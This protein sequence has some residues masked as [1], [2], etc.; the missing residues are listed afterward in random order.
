MGKVVVAVIILLLVMVTTKGLEIKYLRRIPFNDVE[1]QSWVNEKTGQALWE[2]I[3]PNLIE[4]SSSREDENRQDRKSFDL[5]RPSEVGTRE[6]DLTK[7][8]SSKIKSILRKPKCSNLRILFDLSSSNDCDKSIRKCNSRKYRRQIEKWSVPQPFYVDEPK[9]IEME[10]DYEENIPYDIHNEKNTF[11]VTRGKRPFMPKSKE[12][13]SVLL[14]NL[15]YYKEKEN[16]DKKFL[17]KAN[18]FTEDKNNRIKKND[19]KRKE[20]RRKALK[21]GTRQLEDL[22]RNLEKPEEPF[23][24]T[25]GKKLYVR[26]HEMSLNTNIKKETLENG[27]IGKIQKRSI[28]DVPTYIKMINTNASSLLKETNNV[29]LSKKQQL[30]LRTRR[31]S[32]EDIDCSIDHSKKKIRLTEDDE[33]AVLDS[34]YVKRRDKHSDIYDILEVPFFISR[35]KKTFE[36]KNQ[37]ESINTPINNGE[38]LDSI[39]AAKQIF[40]RLFN[41]GVCNIDLC[42]DLIK[43]IRENDTNMIERNRKSSLEEL[44]KKHDLFYVVRGKKMYLSNFLKENQLKSDVN[45]NGNEFLAKDHLS[46]NIKNLDKRYAR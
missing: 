11:F 43:F 22:V 21:L 23:V 27:S 4:R 46:Y 2:D 26:N 42:K 44:F 16:N 30:R 37:Q 18:K 24:L 36:Y 20:E 19:L 35:G 5:E 10:L 3:H 25:R 13:S 38:S 29:T 34:D 9:W 39:E 6:N 31:N 1:K 33:R 14:Q 45:L 8:N 40:Q 7:K 32:C 17:E 12:Q 41:S 28:I 15:Y